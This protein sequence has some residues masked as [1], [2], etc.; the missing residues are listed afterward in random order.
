M[1]NRIS[2]ATIMDKNQLQ[3]DSAY[4]V[5]LEIQIEGTNTV[6]LV[7]NHEDVNWNGND[8]VAFP[9]E[10]DDM[11]E[12]GK[13]L[14]ELVLR[15]SNVK[16]DLE[17]YL[18]QGNGG[19]GATVIVRVVNS[20]HM[21]ITSPEVEISFVCES[22]DTD[23]QWAYF[24]LGTGEAQTKR[25]PQMRYFK[26]SCRFAYG[27]VRC[28]ATTAIQAVYPNC[29]GSLKHCQERQNSTRFGGFPSIPTGGLYA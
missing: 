15:V 28:G 12:D 6:R 8:W 5:L 25:F 10:M 13:E 3:S 24:T 19:V 27:S 21:E 29:N 18:N 2:A 7:R 26:D 16:R 17:P 23:D 9:F 14:P 22:T 11:T 4:L 1:A 20:E